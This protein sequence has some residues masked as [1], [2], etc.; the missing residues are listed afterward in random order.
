MKARVAELERETR[1]RGTKEILLQK[2]LEE[3]KKEL[4]MEKEWGRAKIVSLKTEQTSAINKESVGTGKI[5]FGNMSMGDINNPFSKPT[6]TAIAENKLPTPLAPTFNFGTGKSNI[7]EKSSATLFKFGAK[8]KEEEKQAKPEFENKDK[9][10]GFTSPFASFSFGGGKK[11]SDKGSDGLIDDNK[12]SSISDKPEIMT[13]G[14][15]ETKPEFK[16]SGF[17]FSFGS[18]DK[19]A[20]PTTTT[21]L[22]NFGTSD[23]KVTETSTSSSNLFNFGASS[24]LKETSKEDELKP[25][26]VPNFNFGGDDGGKSKRTFSGVDRGVSGSK[27]G[28]DTSTSISTS[29]ITGT[30]TGKSTGTSTGTSNSGFGFG[31]LSSTSTSAPV[32]SNS[33]PLF[34]FGAPSATTATNSFNVSAA[35][36]KNPFAGLSSVPN[37]FSN[38]SVGF[39]SSFSF[40]SGTPQPLPNANLFKFQTNPSQQ[41]QTNNPFNFPSMNSNEMMAAPIIP[42][43]FGSTGNGNQQST[44]ESSEFGFQTG[45]RAISVPKR[46]RPLPK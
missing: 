31:S 3:Q 20:I 2:Q 16:S 26:V 5:S 1:D 25:V 35:E 42:M 4:E 18:T 43:N 8:D 27:L 17:G 21:N 45:H 30:I 44:D 14:K 11:D 38:G 34:N 23:N 41:G 7:E 46:R 24:S 6:T 29:T 19:N 15:P 37:I 10:S 32:T 22:F 9:A 33:K 12:P 36:T 28:F 13:E 40:N 39:N